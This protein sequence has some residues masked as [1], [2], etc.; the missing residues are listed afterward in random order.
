[1][2]DCVSSA[3]VYLTMGVLPATAQRDIEI[4]G[5]LGQLALCDQDEQNV[6]IIVQHNLSFFDEKFGGWSGLVRN[7]AAAYGL[8]DPL[9][10]MGHPWRSDR[11]RAHSR[12]VVTNH[13]DSKLRSDLMTGEGEE[14]SSATF[15]DIKYLTTSTPM[16]IWQK[17][18][19]DSIAVKEATPVS[20]MYCGVYFTREFMFRMK[21][22]KTP[23]CVCD[24]S[25]PENLPHFLL[26][27][28]IYNNIREQYIPN[29]IQM[30]SHIT[31]IC[32][33][34]KFLLISILDPLSSKLPDNIR[35]NWSS[36]RDVYHLSR[37]FVYRMHL[38]REKLYTEVDG[39]T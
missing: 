16:R 2:P 17:A 10:Y 13:W 29:Y 27:C 24:N 35:R 20:W 18:G 33:N 22:V 6:R 36:V 28:S 5:L 12:E 25:T 38:K 32:D 14:K 37:K 15:V 26:N 1:M 7:T 19:L 39:K 9:Q 30:N 3:L 34:E 4:L 31:S 21:M 11:W 8:P 23:F